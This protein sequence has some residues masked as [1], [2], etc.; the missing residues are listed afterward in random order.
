MIT[1]FFQRSQNNNRESVIK[2]QNENVHMSENLGESDSEEVSDHEN[3]EQNDIDQ[4]TD[5]VR[6]AIASPEYGGGEDESYHGG[7]D[8]ESYHGGGD[9]ESDHGSR[10]SDHE[11]EADNTENTLHGISNRNEF[12]KQVAEEV[13]KQFGNSEEIRSLGNVSKVIAARVVERIEDTKKKKETITGEDKLWQEKP[14]ENLVYCICCV[15]FASHFDVPQ[16][17]RNFSRGNFGLFR[18]LGGRSHRDFKKMILRH[19][20]NPLHV[21]CKEKYNSQEANEKVNAEKNRKA[22]EMVVMNAAHVLKDPAGSATDFQKL[23]NKD[24]LLMGL[25]YPTKNDGKQNYFE[26]RTI[27]HEKLRLK[28]HK[29]MKSV[30]FFSVSLDKV[31]VDGTGYTVVVTYYFWHGELRVFMNELLVMSSDMFDGRGVAKM[32]CQCLMKTL[33]LTLQELREKLEHL[34]FDGVYADTADRVRGGGS[35][36]LSEH[37]EQYLGFGQG[38]GNIVSNN[39]D[40]GHRLQLTLG[41]ILVRRESEHSRAYQKTTGEMFTLMKMWKDDKDGMIF[42]ETSQTL[43][44]PTLKQRASQETRWAQ[45]DLGAKK[46]FFRNSPTI[47]NCLGQKMQDYMIEG[48]VMKHKEVENLM[49]PLL[50]FDFW[51]MMIGYTQFQNIVVE[52]SLESQHS[53]YFASSCLHLVLKAVEKLKELGMY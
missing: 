40:L 33:G 43:R 25:S 10:D 30:K 28:V 7:G 34:S 1:T 51:I 14:E 32:L 15:K 53:S 4:D 41:D 17:L 39:W 18:K 6:E 23:N 36:N 13:A 44:H 49:K 38:A 11:D 29:M 48:N 50:T 3:G 37:V 9:D 27:F 26:L 35:L 20:K 12:V 42:Q 46:N 19:S 22:C 21:W 31:T 52:A 16:R 2:D 47:Y 8:N 24:Q 45:A 5:E